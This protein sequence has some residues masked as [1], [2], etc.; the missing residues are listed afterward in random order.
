MEKKYKFKEY[1][2]KQK[3]LGLLSCVH[4]SKS[5]FI[6]FDEAK[7]KVVNLDLEEYHLNKNSKVITRFKFTIEAVCLQKNC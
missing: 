7:T 6:H 4:Y 1:V 5:V 2:Y 3:Q